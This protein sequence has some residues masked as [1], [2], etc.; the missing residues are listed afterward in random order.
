MIKPIYD[1]GY[2][3]AIFEVTD[4]LHSGVI[5]FV[6]NK[7]GTG[8]ITLDE[9]DR[10]FIKTKWT[11]WSSPLDDGYGKYQFK[12]NEKKIIVQRNG[13]RASASCNPI[14][15]FNLVKGLQ[16]SLARLR[17]KEILKTI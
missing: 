2:V 1:Y 7:L 8:L 10:Y 15:K 11:E 4:V 5:S 12:T 17:V 14:D 9:F 16:L 13:L 3:G 6:H